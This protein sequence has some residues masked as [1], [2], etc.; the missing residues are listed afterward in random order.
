VRSAVVCFTRFAPTMRRKL[1]IRTSSKS[2]AAIRFTRTV[3]EDGKSS[4]CGLQRINILQQHRTIVGKKNTCPC[5]FEKVNI[6]EKL[7]THPC[8]FRRRCSFLCDQC[9]TQ[10]IIRGKNNAALG[11]SVGHS[12]ISHRLESPVA[13][14]SASYHSFSRQMSD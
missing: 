13:V 5:C 1:A 8:S 11:S 9:V 2:S 4:P 3:F 7:F 14:Q 12:R 10:C 6:E